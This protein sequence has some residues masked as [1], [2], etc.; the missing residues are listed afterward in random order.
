MLTAIIN[1][2]IFFGILFSKLT[3]VELIILTPCPAVLMRVCIRTMMLQ[4]DRSIFLIVS[5]HC[6]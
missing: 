2:F 5:A 1:M 6:L 3:D 4:K